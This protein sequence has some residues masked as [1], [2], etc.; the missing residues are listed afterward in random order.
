MKARVIALTEVTPSDIERW[1]QLA[2]RASEPNPFLEPFFLASAGRYREDA[3]STQLLLV[4]DGS[5]L[6]AVLAFEK[7]KRRIRGLPINAI[8]TGT[9]FLRTESERWHPLV[10][11]TRAAE[12]IECLLGE[13]RRLHLPGLID[14]E[15]MPEGPLTEAW[16]LAAEAAHVPIIERGGQEYAYVHRTD[17]TRPE[18]PLLDSAPVQL[19]L[20]HLS[21]RTRKRFSRSLRELQHQF[22]GELSLVDRGPDP[23]ALAEFLRLQASGWKGDLTRGGGAFLVTGQDRWFKDATA[24]FRSEGRLSVFLMT[25]GTETI[26]SAVRFRSG[27]GLFAVHDA[28]NED[29]A[30][31]GAGGLGRLAVISR[32]MID[33]PVDFYDSS[34][35]PKYVDSTHLYPHRRRFVSLLLA[36]RGGV[37]KAVLRALPT[38]RRLRD[39]FAR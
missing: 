31:Y 14:L 10:D 29:F 3:Q 32:S 2:Q 35:H 37:S 17:E 9:L 18:V 33:Y 6:L 15:R 24:S 25:A 16:Y 12:A 20:E 26:Y 7:M 21:H 30:Q 27:N 19:R 34:M 39:R 5:Q 8:T 22:G 4:E 38:A 36:P 23:D 13:A 11:A 28:F 1:Q